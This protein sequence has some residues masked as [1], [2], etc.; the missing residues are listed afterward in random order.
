MQEGDGWS[1]AYT[2]ALILL[3]ATI[4]KKEEDEGVT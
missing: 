4:E 3:G 2:E 1:R